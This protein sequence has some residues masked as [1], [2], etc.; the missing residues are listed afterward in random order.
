LSF[1]GAGI[2]S[3]MPKYILSIFPLYIILGKV[4]ENSTSDQVL[5]V[6]FAILQGFLMVFWTNGF[7]FLI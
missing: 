6:T 2:F 4:K 3:S 1:A 5:T 7:I